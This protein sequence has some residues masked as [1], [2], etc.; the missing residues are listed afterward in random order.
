MATHGVPIFSTTL[1]PSCLAPWCPKLGSRS[2]PVVS[3]RTDTGRDD[4]GEREVLKKS[5]CAAQN[6]VLLQGV[7][8]NCLPSPKNNST[9]TLPPHFPML[10]AAF[11]RMCVHLTH[12]A[13]VSALRPIYWGQNHMCPL[14][15]F[16]GAAAFLPPFPRL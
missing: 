7:K 16:Q 1:L 6:Y 8:T 4:G 9:T 14:P 5:A 10:S 11:V 15:K 13:L 3:L 12:F 2:R